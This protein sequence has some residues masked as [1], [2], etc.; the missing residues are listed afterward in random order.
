VR[1]LATGGFVADQR[2][3]VLIGGTSTG[4]TYLGIA[5]AGALL[6]GGA[7]GR[8]FNV[9]DLVNRLKTET[10]S[11]KQGRMADDL[12][13]MDFVILD[14]LGYLPFA[15][16]GGQLRRRENGPPDCFPILLHPPDPPPLRAYLDL[17]AIHRP[18]NRLKIDHWWAIC[19]SIVSCR[20]IHI[21]M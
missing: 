13:R 2:N 8:I 3:V 10:L 12:T 16:S 6:R 20:Y 19:P 11:D 15:Q 1:D 17:L 9:V 5:N 21:V 14:E 7:R 18:S 4:K